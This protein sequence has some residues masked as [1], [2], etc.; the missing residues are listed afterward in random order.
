MYLYGNGVV[1]S[2]LYTISLA[3][4]AERY[5]TTFR[6]G[7]VRGVQCS[8]GRVTGVR[9]DDGGITCGTV[10]LA[11]GPWAKAAEAWLGRSIPVEPFKGEIL[12]MAAAGTS[13]GSRYPR[14]RDVVI[15][16]RRRLDLVWRDN[17]VARI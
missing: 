14:T 15:Q 16:P 8:A 12:R 2:Y 9:L 13:A 3:R 6:T 4:A 7:E 5:G 1:D 10:V 17:G 11:M